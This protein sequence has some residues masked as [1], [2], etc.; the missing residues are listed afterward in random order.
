[1]Q[2]VIGHEAIRRELRTLAHSD[3]PPHALLISGPESLGRRMLARQFALL[4]NCEAE[5]EAAPCGKC[6]PCRLID[7]HN[8]PDISTMAPGDS[9][10]AGEGHDPH[11]DARDIRTCQ[12]RG[13]ID[14]VS[15]FPFEAKYRVITLEPADRL[16]HVAS[17]VFLKTLEEPPDHTVF[18]LVT[19]A[20]ELL[21]DTIRSRC[22]EIV[23]GIVP[24]PEIEKA[25]LDRGIEPGTAAAAASAARGR[26]GRAITFSEKPDLMDD[27]GRLLARC[28][29][30]AAAGL[31][32]RFS[33][34]GDLAERWRRD[35]GLVFG[36][37]E[38][39]ESFWEGRL[40]DA[41]ASQAG[42]AAATEALEALRAID[43]AREDL[44]AQVIAR[45]A[46]ELML[47][48]FPTVTLAETEEAPAHA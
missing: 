17:N 24:R 20:P 43:Y 19:A 7:G 6:R 5:D 36:E 37:L 27:R 38:V 2:Q 28:G 32:Q 48:R 16:Y 30:I 25:L 1:M 35:R 11:P 10:C 4:L 13:A 39:W 14:L 31:A 34:A 46:L 22:R 3:D 45:A 29:E 18:V 33:H 23:V 15:R 9:F 42:T 21:L 8:H 12:V 47:L 40:N 26:P 41:A 44:E